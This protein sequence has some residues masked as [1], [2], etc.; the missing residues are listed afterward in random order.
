MIMS[1]TVD[2]PSALVF[3]VAIPLLSAVVFGI[4]LSTIPL[5][6]RVQKN[7][8]GVLEK[9]AE[10]LSGV[11]VIRAFCKEDEER[12]E[13]KRRNSLL[14]A[15][16]KKVG[17]ISALLNPLTYVI[18]NL[19]II[20]LVYVGAVRVDNGILTTGEVLALYNYMSQILIELIKLANLII[21]ITRA[22]AS[23]SRI[24]DT[25]AI[26]PT[27]DMGVDRLTCETD[28][29][30][31]FNN[32]SLKYDG[33]GDNS[34]SKI[35][36]TAK[37]GDTV[38]IIGG[39][40]SGKSSLVN[41]IPGFYKATEGEVR[42]FGK[43]VSEYSPQA[44]REAVGVV[45]QGAVLF[46]GSIRENMLWGKSD[47][48][49]EEINDALKTAQALDVVNDK[50]GLDAKIEQGGRNLSGGQR[51]RLTIARA[52][53]RKPKLLIL[54]DSASALDYATDAALRMAI[55]KIGGETTTFIVS[56]RASSVMH[57]D[58][59]I[60]LEDGEAVGMG[61]HEE[62]IKDCEVYKEI[63]YSQFEEKGVKAN[64]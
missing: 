62:L 34:L 30:V 37:K 42:I 25:L 23:A 56:Q 20:Y 40:G 38:G 6:K 26:A 57:A 3:T 63:Y 41:L 8:D 19:A 5:Y 58:L 61:R 9:T 11:R 21:T 4:L 55:K 43:E 29:A 10:N 13:F 31:S 27:E 47:A 36:F 16:S 7:T 60:V 33:A 44:I 45:P 24:K 39:T 52:L 18:I 49:D 46:S 59:I 48:T 64:G 15:A 17:A 12:A 2:V 35:S 51:Q 28:E 14:T 53:I 1:F 32:V 22:L 54:D 50:G